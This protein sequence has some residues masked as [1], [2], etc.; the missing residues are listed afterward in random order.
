ML[1]G[2]GVAIYPHGW[3]SLEIQQACGNTS[4]SYHLGK[5]LLLFL[6]LISTPNH[7]VTI[8]HYLTGSVYPM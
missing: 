6:T 1:I 3:D 8:N 4:D 7:S 5:F 2:G